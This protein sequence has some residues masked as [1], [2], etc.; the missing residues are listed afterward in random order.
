[1]ESFPDFGVSGIVWISIIILLSQSLLVS[2][3]SGHGFFPKSIR[4]SII[5]TIKISFQSI[6]IDKWSSCTFWSSPL[7]SVSWVASTLSA[8][9]SASTLIDTL[10][11]YHCRKAKYFYIWTFRTLKFFVTFAELKCCYRARK[12][13]YRN[14]AN[15]WKSKLYKNGGGRVGEGWIPRT[16]LRS[17]H[18]VWTSKR[19]RNKEM[20]VL[21]AEK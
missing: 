21:D 13:K 10:I 19:I 5:F 4:I 7:K 2:T 3:V 15:K 17:G 9:Q 16:W 11:D 18:E 14:T 20:I 8:N 12:N 1:M 6:I